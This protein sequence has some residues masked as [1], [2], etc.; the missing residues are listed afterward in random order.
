MGHLLLNLITIDHAPSE[1]TLD[2]TTRDIASHTTVEVNPSGITR[3]RSLSPVTAITHLY[4]F[5]KL[6]EVPQVLICGQRGLLLAYV[7]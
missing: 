5:S 7:V 4:L 2:I 6:T 1:F 3:R